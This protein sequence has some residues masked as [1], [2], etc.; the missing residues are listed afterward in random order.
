MLRRHRRAVA[1]L[2]FALLSPVAMLITL[3]TI[4][5][6]RELLISQQMHNAA[7]AI[8]QAAEKLSVTTDP[9]TGDVTT[10][11]TSDQ[12]QRAMSAIYAEIPGL[13]LGNGGSLFPGYF[14]V[15]LSS[16]TYTPSCTAAS[17]CG[18]QTPVVLWTTVLR[19]GGAQLLQT[20]YR[21]CGYAPQQVAHLPNNGTLLLE[22]PSP[23]LAGGSSMTLVPQVVADVVYQ[24]VPWFPFFTSTTT[25]Y[26]TAT[27]PAPIGAL[28]AAITLNTG[29]STSGV[30]A[31]S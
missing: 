1:A 2:E 11:L 26:A 18:A 20:F 21:P 19:S 13:N 14:G 30:V 16:I 6:A 25:L 9:A 24:F 8:A 7:D 3:A 22:F 12:M 31:C 29:A 15:G 4:D 23:V 27:Y 17:G 28:N 10:E 5:A